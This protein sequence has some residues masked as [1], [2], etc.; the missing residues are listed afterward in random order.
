[1]D[2]V[3]TEITDRRGRKFGWVGGKNA[4][5]GTFSELAKK[6]ER[7]MAQ[8]LQDARELEMRPDDTMVCT[9]AKSGWFIYIF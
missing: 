7:G 6:R 2:I 5:H 9:Y 4:L 3:E 1:M 8:M